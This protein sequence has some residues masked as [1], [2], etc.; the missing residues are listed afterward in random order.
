METSR[1]TEAGTRGGGSFDS[2]AMERKIFFAPAKFSA[3]MTSKTFE[4]GSGP[5]LFLP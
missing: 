5:L 4:I 2:S 1:C 3:R